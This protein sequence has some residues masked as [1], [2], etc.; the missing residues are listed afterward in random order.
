MKALFLLAPALVLLL[1]QAHAQVF[2]FDHDMLS[3]IQKRM[4]ALKRQSSAPADQKAFPHIDKGFVSELVHRLNENGIE[5]AA[6]KEGKDAFWRQYIHQTQDPKSGV[7]DQY[8]I[9]IL[10]RPLEETAPSKNPPLRFAV[11]RTEFLR[12]HCLHER[13]SPDA[14]GK[15]M[16]E[17]YQY[18]IAPNGAILE[19]H[20]SQA[21]V[22][23]MNADGTA[24]I[25]SK[26]LV[27]SAVPLD[28]P[29]VL[30]HWKEIEKVFRT[31]SREYET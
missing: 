7:S 13:V 25:D 1:S 12:M 28:D 11:I 3:D 6:E 9:R 20:L 27:E 21:P 4:K 22:K 19:V 16:L 24:E 23:A 15:L 14:A 26:H 31:M 18:V 5:V 17:Q 29:R 2:F 30:G 10:I 8:L